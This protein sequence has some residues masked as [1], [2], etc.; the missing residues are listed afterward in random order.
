[1]PR[2]GAK[3]FDPSLIYSRDRLDYSL[4]RSKVGFRAKL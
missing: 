2:T 4:R 1:L 3:G